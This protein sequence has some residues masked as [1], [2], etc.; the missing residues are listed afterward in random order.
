MFPVPPHHHVSAPP[1]RKKNY[2]HNNVAVVPVH[3]VVERRMRD[4]GSAVHLYQVNYVLYPV[5]DIYI[6]ERYI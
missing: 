6:E 5:V 3:V 4:L 2:I 1:P